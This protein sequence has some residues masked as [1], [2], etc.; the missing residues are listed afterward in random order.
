MLVNIIEQRHYWKGYFFRVC[1]GLEGAVLVYTALHD[2][3]ENMK[4][5][6]VVK[7]FLTGVSMALEI[8]RTYRNRNKDLKILIKLS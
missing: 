7:A 3:S 4:T 5:N 8:I 6:V 1:I 2:K